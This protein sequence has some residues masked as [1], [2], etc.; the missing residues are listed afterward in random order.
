[1]QEPVVLVEEGSMIPA[2]LMDCGLIRLGQK[3]RERYE[4]GLAERHVPTPDESEEALLARHEVLFVTFYTPDYAEAVERWK[5]TL[6]S[7]HLPY[8]AVAVEKP[9]GDAKTAWY[10]SETDK[11]AFL[12]EMIEK[13]PD[14]QLFV[15]CDADGEMI[16]FPRALWNIPTRL[17]VHYRAFKEPCTAMVAVKRD[18]EGLLKAWQAESKKSFAARDRCPSQKA[19]KNVLEKGNEKWTQLPGAYALLWRWNSRD[20]AEKN[21]VFI[22]ERWN[23]NSKIPTKDPKTKKRLIPRKSARRRKMK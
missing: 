8:D 18:S 12:Q 3:D 16:R 1:M 20:R 6:E 21:G 14:Y 13:H 19:L 23:R 11:A 4:R 9:P 7:F 5:K 17:A 10:S 2:S 15:W 22:H